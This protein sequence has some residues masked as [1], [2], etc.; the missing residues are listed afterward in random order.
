MYNTLPSCKIG[1]LFELTGQVF[2]LRYG[3]FF[4]NIIPGNQLGEPHMRTKKK[5]LLLDSVLVAEQNCESNDRNY[6][7]YRYAR[8]PD[9]IDGSRKSAGCIA[10]DALRY[11]RR[12]SQKENYLPGRIL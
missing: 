4:I 12:E 11:K 2:C 5:D 10:A 8:Y 7:S 9:D 3:S 6:D 1:N